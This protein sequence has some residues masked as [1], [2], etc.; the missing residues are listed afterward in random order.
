MSWSPA[1]REARRARGGQMDWLDDPVLSYKLV[2]DGR[3]PLTN[4]MVTTRKA[5]Q[6]DL[7][8]GPIDKGMRVRRETR[9]SAD[10]ETIETRHVCPS[11]CEAIARGEEP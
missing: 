10:G 11:C 1:M 8:G 7:C 6:C 9:R 2:C 5:H 3:D 4:V